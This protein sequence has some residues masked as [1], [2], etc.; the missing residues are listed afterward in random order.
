MCISCSSV[1][2]LAQFLFIHSVKN[3]IFCILVS[4]TGKKL[5]GAPVQVVVT[6]E[7]HTFDLDVEALE[8]ILLSP[9]VRDK[10]VVVV[11]VAGAFRKGKSFMLD[12]FLRFLNAGVRTHID[13]CSVPFLTAADTTW[14]NSWTFYYFSI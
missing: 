2:Y 3:C 14:R 13:F 11:S 4:A 8:K 6:N 5:K 7:N 1:L 9:D 12:F 10:Q